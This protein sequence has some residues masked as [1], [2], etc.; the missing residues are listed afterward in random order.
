MFFMLNLSRKVTLC[1]CLKIQILLHSLHHCKLHV[2]RENLNFIIFQ[3][4]KSVKKSVK[5]MKEND[6]LQF[7]VQCLSVTSIVLSI[8]VVDFSR[9]SAIRFRTKSAENLNFKPRYALAA[10]NVICIDVCPRDVY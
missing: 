5:S 3:P 10:K 6:S 1:R 4:Q 7:T 9:L 2:Q 8:I